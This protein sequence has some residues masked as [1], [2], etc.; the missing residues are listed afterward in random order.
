[1]S[2]SICLKNPIK[3]YLNRQILFPQ[4][5]NEETYQCPSSHTL[6]SISLI[7]R[8]FNGR[9]CTS[10]SY[11]P[12]NLTLEV[13]RIQIHRQD[14]LAK[15]HTVH[16]VYNFDAKLSWFSPNMK[17]N[18]RVFWYSSHYAH[19]TTLRFFQDN[20]GLVTGLLWVF[21]SFVWFFSIF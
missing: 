4:T 20:C 10:S 17:S 21:E 9:Q 3:I 2:G 18:N 16:I 5:R 1:V 8:I 13:I 15:V 14:H 12:T 6:P 19:G 11:R 7:M